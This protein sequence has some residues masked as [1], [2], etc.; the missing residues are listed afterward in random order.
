M[1]FQPLV[2]KSMQEVASLTS[3]ASG[4]RSRCLFSGS[5]DTCTGNFSDFFLFGIP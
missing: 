1:F 4:I 2:E 5:Q 3:G